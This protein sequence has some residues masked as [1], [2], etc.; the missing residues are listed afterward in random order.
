MAFKISSKLGTLRCP[1]VR[2]TLLIFAAIMVTKPVMAD[3]SH[4]FAMNL[5]SLIGTAEACQ[6]ELDPAEV[7]RVTREHLQPGDLEFADLVSGGASLRAAWL[8]QASDAERA[9]ACTAAEI[10]ARN[11]GIAAS[12]P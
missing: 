7:S 6:I 8:T 10:N 11:L 1:P 2:A 9:A 3:E 12:A 5:G 4:T